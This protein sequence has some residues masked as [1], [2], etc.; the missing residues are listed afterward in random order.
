MRFPSGEP[1]F[2]APHREFERS[3]SI[4]ISNLAG[5]VNTN[6][7]GGRFMVGRYK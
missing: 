2:T 7:L 1:L 4:R 6:L 5:L 3:V